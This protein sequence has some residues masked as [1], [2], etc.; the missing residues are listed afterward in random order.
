MALAT[1]VVPATLL[2]KQPEASALP[3]TRAVTITQYG[4]AQC[5]SFRTA[6][7]TLPE[8]H[9]QHRTKLFAV[10]HELLSGGSHQPQGASPGLNRTL[11]RSG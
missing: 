10:A 8:P 4:F 7:H 6:T 2:E 9:E 11:A 5:V 3:L 1:G